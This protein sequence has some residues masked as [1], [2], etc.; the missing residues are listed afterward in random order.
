[1]IS[2]QNFSRRSI[3]SGSVAAALAMGAWPLAARAQSGTVRFIL[4]NATGSGVDTI[5]RA[6]QPA[7]SKAFNASVVVD[8]QP[9]AGGVV[10]LQALARSA[11][12]GNTLSIVSN[13]V[14]IFPSVLKSLPFDM[15]GDFTPIAVVGATPMV[16]VVNPSKVQA[17]NSK[18]FIALLKSKPGALNFAS[19]GNGTILHL[20]TELFLEQAGVSAKHIPYKGVGPMV[21]DLIGGQVEFGTAALPSVQAHIKSGALRAI[22]VLTAQR[23]PAAPEIPTFAEQG[24]PNFVVDAWFAVIGPKGLS[25]AHV[26]KAH[27]AVVAAFDD[28]AVREAMTKQGNT[29]SIG[30]PEQAQATFRSELAKYAALVKK[31]GIE[32]Q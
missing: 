32:P 22:G 31:A 11:P 20:A 19:G 2:R 8:N 12:D 3:L 26:K 1:M 6:A 25:P 14:V 16:L 7:L 29:I 15:P 28:P 17:T 23:T 13:N 18:E 21:T 4:P 30:T 24:L 9:G 5:T 27:D 10:G